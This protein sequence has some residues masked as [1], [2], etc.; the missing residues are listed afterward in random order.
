[1]IFYFDQLL[2]YSKNFGLKCIILYFKGEWGDIGQPQGSICR[3]GEY[4]AVRTYIREIWGDTEYKG[5]LWRY[6]GDI[7]EIK[8][9]LEHLREQGPNP[10]P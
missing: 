8:R 2:K 4:E 5:D 10:Y 9:R 1:M 7:R 3:G 6:G